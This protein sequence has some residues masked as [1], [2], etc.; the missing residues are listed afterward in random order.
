MV[1]TPLVLLLAL[2]A[3]LP[4]AAQGLSAN[5]IAQ[6]RKEFAAS[7]TNKDGAL[8]RSEVLARTANMAVKGR[9]P[10]PVH[11]KRLADLWFVSADLNKD[12]KVTEP[13]AQSLLAAMVRRQAAQH[14]ARATGPATPGR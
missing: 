11:A 7:D 9:R 3:A 4:A 2:S 1:R 8:S 5:D 14:A 10:D 12:G 13:E 6:F